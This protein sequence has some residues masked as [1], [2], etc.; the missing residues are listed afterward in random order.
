MPGNK[1]KAEETRIRK[2]SHTDFSMESSKQ[3]CG[4]LRAATIIPSLQMR[5]Q[6]FR[7]IK[8]LPKNITFIRGPNI[9]ASLV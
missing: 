5:T 8:S 2:T 6:T 1:L 9:R 3:Y 7:K 4:G